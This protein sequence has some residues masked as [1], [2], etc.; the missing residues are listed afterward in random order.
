MAAAAGAGADVKA[1]VAAVVTSALNTDAKGLK[2]PALALDQKEFLGLL[3][4]L[5]GQTEKLQNAPGLNMIPQEELVADMVVAFL[6][7]YTQPKGPLKV[8]KCTY[9]AGRSN[10]AI[11]YAADPALAAGKDKVVSFV[12]CH[13]D[14][15]PAGS[16]ESWKKADPFK[17]TVA[18]DGDSL[19]GRGVTDC[20]GH[21]ALMSCVFKA[22]AVS[23]PKLAVSV[24][25]VFIANEEAA[26]ELG[27]GV[28]EMVKRGELDRCKNGPLIWMDSADFGPTMGTGGA[29]VWELTVNGKLF[30]SG[31]PHKAINA[32]ELGMEA[33]KYVQKRFYADFPPHKDEALYKYETGSSMKPTLIGTPPGGTNQIPGVCTIT[34]DI[35][36][37]PFYGVDEVKAKVEQYVAEL[38][39]NTLPSLGWSKYEL[40]GADPLKGKVTLKWLGLPYKGV[41]CNMKSLGYQALFEAVASVRGQVVPFSLTG[42]LPCIRDLQDAGFDVQV[43]GF[44]KM[45]TYHCPDEM[46]S[47]KDMVDGFK[48][49]MRIIDTLNQSL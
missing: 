15:V 2:L 10:V 45:S 33:T 14:V 17:L 43:T 28:D 26:A 4:D 46:A 5:I 11:E 35:R 44:G 13:M 21:V 36:L 19:F 48:I 31:F 27:I 8:R 16:K 24:L 12:G 47:L 18:A 32:I 29:I 34:G 22:L 37:T 20:L 42:S 40:K 7:P 23:A 9:K 38:D 39:V 1:Q 25:G 41:A 49:T 30:H 3:S 6:A